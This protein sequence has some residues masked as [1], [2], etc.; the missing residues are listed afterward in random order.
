MLQPRLG[1]L[2]HVFHAVMRSR[3]QI[4]LYPDGARHG[5]GQ[6]KLD[7]ARR[8]PRSELIT[9]IKSFQEAAL[10]PIAS[11]QPQLPLE[12]AFMELLPEA[13]M[14]AYA[15]VDVDEVD[16]T[17]QVKEPTP[18]VEALHEAPPTIAGETISWIRMRF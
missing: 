1:D 8:A 16:E 14:A 5:A 2:G 11:W 12:L 9:A 17:I 13:P 15:A 10:K 18:P 6:R 7:Q 4:P 3:R